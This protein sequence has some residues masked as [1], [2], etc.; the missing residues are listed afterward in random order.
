MGLIQAALSAAG[1]VL[2]DQWKEYFYCDALDNN[3]LVAK[4]VKKTSAFSANAYGCDNIITSG[5]GIAIADGQCMI[6]VEDGKI[7]EFCAEPGNFIWD[8]SS[9]PSI[10]NGDL[11]ENI[12]D[13]FAKIGARFT[14][15]GDTGKDQRIYYFNTKEILDN[16]F[17]TP[18]PIPFAIV[19]RNLN[20]FLDTAVRCSGTYSYRITDPMLFYANVCGNVASVFT[21]D[22]IDAQLRA[23]FVDALQPAFGKISALGIRPSELPNHAA[24]LRDLMNDEL[25]RKWSETRG[26]EIVSVALNPITLPEE[27]ANRIKD[28]QLA[29][30]NRDPLM[31]AATTVAAS[32]QAARDAAKNP[33]GAA[34]AMMG[35]NMV[36]G[37]A[38]ANAAALFAAGAQAQPAPAAPA[39]AAWT[40]ECGSVNTGNF[41]PN[42]GKPRPAAAWTCDCGT[43]NTGNFCTNCGKPRH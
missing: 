26:I 27:D 18:N 33:N 38:A 16:K 15:G 30:I 20:L 36:Q 6:I 41:C 39:G 10:F 22:E 13:T 9:E 4:G 7:V 31:A 40:C 43:V 17:G 1:S 28:A 25:T 32:A 34:A 12:K 19:D 24:D 23:E 21:R 42:C 35:V 8:A 11:K 3:V 14:M 5:S 2:Q 37:N 29:A